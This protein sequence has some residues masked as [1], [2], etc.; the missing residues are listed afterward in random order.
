MNEQITLPIQGASASDSPAMPQVDRAEYRRLIAARW[1]G[2]ALRDAA[3][4][5][6]AF[7]EIHDQLTDA[8]RAFARDPWKKDI[9]DRC[10]NPDGTLTA[11]LWKLQE[12][13]QPDK[14]CLYPLLD[15][16]E[17]WQKCHLR[18]GVLQYCQLILREIEKP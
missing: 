3:R 12:A 13:I 16:C 7:A 10:L 11:Y 17:H 4:N 8:M 1:T 6:K 2:D 14:S 18:R 5:H 9:H 15:F